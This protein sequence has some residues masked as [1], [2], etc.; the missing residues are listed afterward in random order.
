MMKN[1]YQTLYD[2]IKPDPALLQRVLREKRR[3]RPRLRRMVIAAAMVAALDA[4]CCARDRAAVHAGLHVLRG[5]GRADGGGF[6]GD[7]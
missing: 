7:P 1:A 6:R 2:P 3:A 4:S 5:P